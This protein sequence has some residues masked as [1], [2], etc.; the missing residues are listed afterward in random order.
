MRAANITIGVN[1]RIPSPPIIERMVPIANF[2]V[3]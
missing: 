1:R 2:I 3:V